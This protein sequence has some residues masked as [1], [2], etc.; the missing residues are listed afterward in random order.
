[1]MQPRKPT[2]EME[3][4]TSD[5]SSSEAKVAGPYEE[6]KNVNYIEIPSVKIEKIVK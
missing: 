2:R 1:M 4:S 3:D 6:I 5:S